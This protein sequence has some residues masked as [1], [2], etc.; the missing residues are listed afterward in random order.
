MSLEYRFSYLQ[1]AGYWCECTP[2]Y[3]GPNCETKINECESNPC[4]FNGKCLDL[5][6]EFKCECYSGYSGLTCQE[7]I[8]ECDEMS[9]CAPF[10]KCIDLHPDYTTLTPSLGYQCDCSELN[11]ELFKTNRNQHISWSGSNCTL[12]LNAC[13]TYSHLCQ[14]NS[15]CQ[16]V[17]VNTQQDIKCECQ[18][19]WT[20]KYCQIM[21]TIHLDGSYS[22]HFTVA[23]GPNFLLKLGFRIQS[24]QNVMPLLFLE[25]SA[26][27]LF[28]IKIHR[29]YLSITNSQIDLNEKIAF[30]E[31][32]AEWHSIELTR[33][34]ETDLFNVVYSV[35]SLHLIQNKTINHVFNLM[36]NS[37]QFGKLFEN[38]SLYLNSACVR[39]VMLNDAQMFLSSSQNKMIKFGCEVSR[40]NEYNETSF[41]SKAAEPITCQDATDYACFNNGTCATNSDGFFCSCSKYFTGSR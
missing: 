14:H 9:P 18:P 1:A 29:K 33:N 36:P 31:N 26:A 13:Q 2:G 24:S 6:N 27:L 32:S 4:G 41:E 28:E 11:E 34:A 5:V 7:N 20:G 15:E 23:N 17:L 8:N 22:P 3:T 25:H 37:V 35:P 12:K 10:T 30:Y 38:E 39:D 19:G 40:M 16:S 21:T